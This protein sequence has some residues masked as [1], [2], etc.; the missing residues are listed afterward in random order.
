MST[1]ERYPTPPPTAPLA[2]PPLHPARAHPS[3]HGNACYPDRA[4]TVLRDM[5]QFHRAGQ[6][7]R[8]VEQLDVPV[9][10]WRAEM[11]RSARLNGSRIH[12]V[13]LGSTGPER[14]CQD[15]SVYA[16]RLDRTAEAREPRGKALCWRRV[17]EL[18]V[19]VETW[20]AVLRRAARREGIRIR[21]FLVPPA[22]EADLTDQLVYAVWVGPSLPST[23]P[24]SRTS[25]RRTSPPHSVR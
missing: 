15:Q 7:C 1:T 17:D 14:S 19:P 22:E 25:P 10:A 12:T 20:R 21:T 24:S 9:E 11:R 3:G 18:A 2:A 8:R 5:T 16:V 13:V 23:P 6:V 4:G